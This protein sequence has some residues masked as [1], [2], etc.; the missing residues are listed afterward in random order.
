MGTALH[1]LFVEDSEDDTQLILHELRR[2]GYDPAFKRIETPEDMRTALTEHTWD[3]ILC[4]YVMPHFSGLAALKLFKESGLD[5]PFIIVS[6]RIGE[7]VAVDAMRAGAHDYILKHN[8]TRLV[9]AIERELRE[10]EVRKESKQAAEALRESEEKYRTILENIEE[11]YYEVDLS[12]NYTFFNKSLCELLGRSEDELLG[13]NYRQSMDSK[14]AEGVFQTFNAV[15][16]TGIPTKAFDWTIIRADG[17]RR[18]IEASISLVVD[19][20]GE[21]AGFRGLARDVTE[22]IEAQDALKESEE[23]YRTLLQSMHD[24]VFVHDVHD[25]YVQY[26]TSSKGLLFVSPEE[27]MGRHVRNVLPPDVAE[28]YLESMRRVRTSGE[29]ET[30][31]YALE[32]SGQEYW[33]SNTM[34]VHEDGESIVAVVRDITKRKQVEEAL[35]ESEERLRQ[36]IDLSPLQTFVKDSE[37]RFILLNEAVAESY[38]T[39]VDALLGRKQSDV[40]SNPRQVAMFLQEDAEVLDSGKQLSIPDEPFTYSDGTVHWLDTRKIPIQFGD[41]GTCILGVA[42][43]ITERKRAE[44]ALRESEEWFRAIYEESPIAIN[45]FTS[46]GNLIHANPAL[47]DFV[48]VSSV[49]E[50]KDFNIFEDPNMPMDV[51]QRMRKGEKILYQSVIVFAKIKEAGLYDASRSGV[52]YVDA[53]ASP[54]RYGEIESLHG[55]MVQM[56]DVTDRRKAEEDLKAAAKTAM[57]YLDLMGHD[58]RNH[59]QAIIMATDILKHHGL[60]PEV[61]PVFNLIFESVQNSQ[62]LISK[63]QATR[64]LLSAPLS[65]ASLREALKECLQVLNETYDDVQI[66]V[67]WGPQH[68]IVLADEY[69]GNLMMNI[70]ENAVLHNDNKKKRVWLNLREVEAG[71]EVAIAD[72]GP[73]IFDERK[74]SL[75]DQ[76]RR[77]GGVG[78]HQA[79]K[80]AQKYGGRISVQDRVRGDPSKGAEFHIWFP[81]ST[82]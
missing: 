77:F 70:L 39:T 82:P 74:E 62:D 47:I 30:I 41:H 69:L 17:I 24:L 5:L 76:D 61:E 64:G 16:R 19:S 54:L 4:D 63:I 34:S 31:D 20:A 23:R 7:E 32:V 80:I 78:V 53:G 43:D 29:S 57:L 42:L 22:R 52:S 25:H 66:E 79:L 18:S 36:V 71:Y 10:A 58:I 50:L 35:R 65:D 2:R 11:G 81:K 27:F 3:I 37:G 68:P 51:K 45:V 73:G 49:E 9:P 21:P 55:Y 44:E 60:T 75:F 72:N 46:D 12:G 6:G 38:G 15:Y 40:H 1:L 26:Y 56:V 59:L 14:D 28:Q 8:L 48:G 13:M 33:F 67:K